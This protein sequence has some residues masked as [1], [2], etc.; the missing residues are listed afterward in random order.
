MNTRNN[1]FQN[2]RSLFT[3]LL[4]IGFFISILTL[5]FP[6]VFRPVIIQARYGF[7]LPMLILFSLI[8]FI[9][10]KEK[11]YNIHGLYLLTIMVYSMALAGLWASG[12]SERQVINGLLPDTDA[13]FYYFDALRLGN[14]F[15]FS[16][17]GARRIFYPAFLGLLLSI[18]KGN[19]QITLGIST[20]LLANA[21]FL[22]V[23][24]AW[25]KF[26]GF[27]ASLFF[28]L[29]FSFARLSIGKTMSEILG[30]TMACLSLSFFL[31]YSSNSKPISLFLGSTTLALGLITRA[32]PLGIYPLLL[33]GIFKK[34][35]HRMS[36]L[37][38]III[39]AISLGLVVL[40]FLMISAL[41]APDNSMPFSN[42]AHSLYGLANGGKGWIQIFKDHPEL[43]N[44]AEPQLTHMIYSYTF[45]TI[46]TEPQKLVVGLF[47]QYPQIFN[48]MGRDGF[49]AFFGGE[50]MYIYV[51][52]QILLFGLSFF[53]IQQLLTNDKYAEHQ[54]L[55]Y[56]LLGILIFVPLFPFVD[57]Y[58]MRVYASVIP[59]IIILPAIGLAA[60]YSRLNISHL[61]LKEDSP[62]FTNSVNLFTIG[63]LVFTLLVP[64]IF[65]VLKPS[66][67]YLIDHNCS[68]DD[69][70][71]LVNINQGSY[72]GLLE[73]K[74]I[75]LDWLPYYHES[76]FTKYLHNFQEHTVQAFENV[77]APTFITSTID[78]QN[79]DAAILIF[80]DEE[81]ANQDGPICVRGNWDE[82]DYS[83]FNARV[84][85]VTDYEVMSQEEL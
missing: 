53:A 19:L 26:G 74:V 79:G 31:S 63:L 64:S 78:L 83:P 34:E 80:P 65:W 3:I 25:K 32:G 28:V 84:F 8:I 7:T 14:G 23:H 51:L 76:Q 5:R 2:I 4:G 60:L 45:E 82:Y 12:Q 44:I 38:I 16:F 46:R 67:N 52:C 21:V 57:F 13:A 39:G 37:R 6:Y 11:W 17:F 15:P 75:Y 61:S 58:R 48:F 71:L 29:L 33:W 47:S 85:F 24:A 62:R 36:R 70:T 54:Y 68:P 1:F 43:K 20:F 49:F 22:S 66:S 42:F 18:T 69:H 77:S 73:E 56:G 55:L 50:N 41:I 59:F 81:M 9:L 72:F 30:L 27:A 10:R 40:S 35:Q